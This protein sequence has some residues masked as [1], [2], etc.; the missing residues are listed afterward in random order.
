MTALTDP[1][2]AEYENAVDNEP[3]HTE[4]NRHKVPHVESCRTDIVNIHHS[5]LYQSRPATE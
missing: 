5:S 4:R 1:V 2:D 3:D